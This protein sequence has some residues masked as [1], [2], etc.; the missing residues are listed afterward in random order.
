MRYNSLVWIAQTY[1]SLGEGLR[2]SK[3][4][5]L[6]AG[7]VLQE[8]V[9]RL[10]RHHRQGD[11]GR[12]RG[13][14]RVRSEQAAARREA[15]AVQE[16]RREGD[17]QGAVE[18]VAELLKASKTVLEAQF[19][20]ALTLQDWGQ[21]GQPESEKRLLEA[22][23]EPRTPA[24]RTRLGLGGDRQAAAAA[25]LQRQSQRQAARQYYDACYNGALSRYLYGKTQSSTPKKNEQLEQS[26]MLIDVFAAVSGDV[27]Q[28]T[29]ESS[30]SCTRTFRRR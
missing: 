15:R 18:T 20:A 14:P 29:F 11:E 26:M 3:S 12:E 16:P 7:R 10:C 17:Y 30:T 24:G 8:V 21:S 27:P 5:G 2:G 1:Y 13:R 19:E 4:G 9:R 23:T 25:R 22:F 28:E 6:L